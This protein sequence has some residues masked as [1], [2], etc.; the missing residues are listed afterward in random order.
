MTSRV[1]PML[2]MK[3][4]ARSDDRQRLADLLDKGLDPNRTDEALI[5]PL[6]VASK[7]GALACVRLLIEHGAA[8]D[9]GDP[10]PANAAIAAGKLEIL[11]E[12]LNSGAESGGPEDYDPDYPAPLVVAA[13]AGEASAVEALLEASSIE[14]SPWAVVDDA[15]RGALDLRGRKK[16][17]VLRALTLGLHNSGR[18]IPPAAG[19]LVRVMKLLAQ[20][21]QKSRDEPL[22]VALRDL[23]AKLDEGKAEMDEAEDACLESRYEELFELIQRIPAARRPGVLGVV[24]TSSTT[25]CYCFAEWLLGKGAAAYLCD[26]TGKTALMH[27]AAYGSEQ[28]IVPLLDRGDACLNARDDAGQTALDLLNSRPAFPFAHVIEG[29]LT[30]LYHVRRDKGVTPL[31]ITEAPSAARQAGELMRARKIPELLH[32]LSEG[33]LN[34]EE[35]KLAAGAAVLQDTVNNCMTLLE[36]C[37][38]H[39]A[40]VNARVDR[41]ANVLHNACQVYEFPLRL[42]RRLVEAG[43]D[44]T[45]VDHFGNSVA[46]NV[47]RTWPAGHECRVYMESV[48]AGS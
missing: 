5:T 32:F 9:A 40:D 16:L 1:V 28:L 23:K 20:N 45:V 31:R 42:L 26:E 15:L 11:K 35:W 33:G 44:P 48:L 36:Y 21:A 25:G 2:E 30:Y 27:A 3:A 34:R 12:L 17:S 13:E 19:S 10:P 46:D 38:D 43:A 8:L 39:G 6:A 7:A 24:A 47:G 18:E 14:R 41:G 29:A 4:I 37:L 22:E